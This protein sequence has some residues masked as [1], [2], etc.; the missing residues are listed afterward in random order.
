MFI[1]RLP[2]S[3]IGTLNLP[4]HTARDE[5]QRQKNDTDSKGEEGSTG[6]FG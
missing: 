2:Q 3:A 4:K 6:G 5:E 1:Q